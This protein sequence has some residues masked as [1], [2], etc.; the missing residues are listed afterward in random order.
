[1]KALE[2]TK[3]LSLAT[4]KDDARPALMNVYSNIAADGFRLHIDKALP[5]LEKDKVP[6]DFSVVV[7]PCYKY[8]NH[9]DFDPNYVVTAMKALKQFKC[10][11]VRIVICEDTMKF[12]GKTTDYNDV[13]IEILIPLH[14]KIGDD[15]EIGFNPHF[16][17]DAISG[18]VQFDT[19]SM[20][21]I[22][23][24]KPGNNPAW[25][26][27]QIDD[28]RNVILMPMRLGKE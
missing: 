14:E 20:Y 27:N 25:F 8:V 22:T 21:T 9:I 2:S 17:L 16:L 13:S 24:P 23:A 7:D 10:Y 6:F 3:W 12:I 19:V 15:F 5:S 26:K 11:I 18:Y 28:D 4:A 1:M